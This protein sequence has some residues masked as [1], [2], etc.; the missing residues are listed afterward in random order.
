MQ[1]WN[2]FPKVLAQV[3]MFVNSFAPTVSGWNKGIIDVCSSAADVSN[4]V[5][6]SSQIIGVSHFGRY[7]KKS[8][9]NR[10]LSPLRDAA[11]AQTYQL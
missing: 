7:W 8:T 9:K 1:R 2:K 10:H 11:T 4:R 6:C 5:Q 3:Q